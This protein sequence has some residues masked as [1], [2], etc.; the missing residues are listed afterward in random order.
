MDTSR[1][2]RG[3]LRP[4]GARG[5]LEGEG[6]PIVLRQGSGSRA[7]SLRVPDCQ[8]GT[9]TALGQSPAAGAAPPSVRS[10]VPAVLRSSPSNGGARDEMARQAPHFI[11]D[12]Y[13]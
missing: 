13:F 7:W 8:P 2:G 11:D 1:L 10:R 6:S 4:A 5:P 9:P 3:W 12:D